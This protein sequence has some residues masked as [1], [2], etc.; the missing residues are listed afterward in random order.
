MFSCRCRVS[1]SGL[2]RSGDEQ[3]DVPTLDLN[4]KR[5]TLFLQ[6]SVRRSGEPPEPRLEFA[7]LFIDRNRNG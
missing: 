5:R 4:R 1:R 3:Y 6:M 2:E 7:E